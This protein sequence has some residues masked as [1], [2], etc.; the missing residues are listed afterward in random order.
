MAAAFRRFSRRKRTPLGRVID[1]SIT[2][3]LVVAIVYLARDMLRSGRF[4]FLKFSPSRIS[5]RD[6]TLSPPPEEVV[7]SWGVFVRNCK[8]AFWQRVLKEGGGTPAFVVTLEGKGR[9]VELSFFPLERGAYFLARGEER[10]MAFQVDDWTY[11]EFM[12]TLNRFCGGVGKDG[13]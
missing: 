10:E 3:F 5:I 13:G 9:K 2:I 11:N 7:K 6:C 4:T 8:R 12:E 1:L